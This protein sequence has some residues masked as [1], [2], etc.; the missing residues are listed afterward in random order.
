MTEY[1]ADL[2]SGPVHV[3]RMSTVITDNAFRLSRGTGGKKKVERIGG[4]N[5]H[6]ICRYAGGH[7][8]IPVKIATFD[9]PGSGL[10]PVLMIGRYFQPQ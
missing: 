9:H 2:G 5:R 3:H 7:F 1:P 10:G 8:I 6:A 4:S